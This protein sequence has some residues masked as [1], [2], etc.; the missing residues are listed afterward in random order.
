MNFDLFNEKSKLLINQ[1]Q[2]MAKFYNNQHVLVEHLIHILI[3]N[4]DS[5]LEDFLKNCEIEKLDFIKLIENKILK[6]PKVL[7]ENLNIFLSNELINILEESKTIKNEFND[8]F[9]SPEIIL[10]TIISNK[11][12]EITKLLSE[13]I[14]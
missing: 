7:G 9:I 5:C 13:S 2:N 4:N 1:A 11:D 6:V 3:N 14:L 12:L 8:S 10:Y